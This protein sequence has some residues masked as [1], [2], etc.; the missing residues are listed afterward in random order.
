MT[1]EEVDFKKR[2]KVNFLKLE[3]WDTNSRFFKI[4]TKMRRSKNTLRIL[5]N[6]GNQKVTRTKLENNSMGYFKTLLKNHKA[7]KHKDPLSPILFDMVMDTLSK[8]I[9]RELRNKKMNTYQVN[10]VNSITHLMY[11]NDIV[12]FT[13]ANSKYLKSIKKYWTLSPTSQC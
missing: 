10:G 9:D 13:K 12:N 2:S 8:L 7:I 1:K 5:N 3:Q 11:A 4:A 6:D